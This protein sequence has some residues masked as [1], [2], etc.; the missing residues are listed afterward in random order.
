MSAPSA[1]FHGVTGALLLSAWL[2]MQAPWTTDQQGNATR[3][4]ETSMRRWLQVHAFD[5]AK[6]CEETRAKATEV[7]DDGSRCV[8]AYVVYP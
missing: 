1:R 5:T 3:H 2:L 7:K 6:D 4:P 8:P